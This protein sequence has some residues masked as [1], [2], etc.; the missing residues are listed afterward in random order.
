MVTLREAK[1][2]ESIL[3]IETWKGAI[4]GGEVQD[5]AGEKQDGLIF[6]NIRATHG[7]HEIKRQRRWL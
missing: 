4:R 2:G 1:T 5:V 6:L 3:G 7:E